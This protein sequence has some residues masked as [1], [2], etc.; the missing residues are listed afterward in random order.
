MKSLDSNVLTSDVSNISFNWRR[1]SA[2]WPLALLYHHQILP[3]VLKLLQ[4][5]L[6]PIHKQIFLNSVINTK[7][8][9][10][11]WS[12]SVGVILSSMDSQMA[13]LFLIVGMGLCSKSFTFA[14]GRFQAFAT[15][16]FLRNLSSKAPLIM[17]SPAQP[18]SISIIR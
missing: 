9:N 1:W 18:F 4:Y 7:F 10:L 6:K 12:E 11:L 16:H 5:N 14:P 2:S 3:L 13:S 17:K 15:S 8:S